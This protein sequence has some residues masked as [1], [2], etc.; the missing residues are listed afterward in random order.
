MRIGMVV[1]PAA[2]GIRT[3]VRTLACGLDT[4]RFSCR[5]YG[6]SALD[7]DE[8]DI[9]H[10]HIAI[11]ETTNAL[12]DLRS[13]IRLARCLRKNIDLV[14][15]HGYRGA[16]IGL[17]AARMARVPAL[18]TAHNVP[19]SSG[20][21]AQL[22]LRLF[23]QTAGQVVAVSEAIALPLAAIARPRS[24][25]HVIPN[26]IDPRPF[27][28]NHDSLAVRSK[29]CLPDKAP[30]LVAIGRLAPEKGFDVLIEAMRIPQIIQADV[31]LALIGSG[32]HEEKLR[33][34]I[35]NSS[36]GFEER[37]HL[38]GKLEHVA[39]LVSTADLIVIP[40]RSEGQGIVALEAMAAGTAIVASRVGGL[41][42][43]IPDKLCGLLVPPEDP[44]A[45][46]TAIATLLADPLRRTQLGQH[47][48]E[49]LLREYTATQMV[50]RTETIYESLFDLANS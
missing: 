20:R 47:G 40:S 2:G 6:P 5:I 36:P 38:L 49:R 29:H 18:F 3:H 46:A 19:P 15:A 26:S 48:R 35:Y 11:G 39:P 4:N 22:S 13:V 16:L 44:P 23:G 12:N 27:L 28:E 37:I 42:E 21:V 10:T 8:V 50:S 9:P 24:L 32:P 45:L 7:L 14:H 33:H 17:T 41:I 1:R 30:L 43:T 25:I 31:H 34:L